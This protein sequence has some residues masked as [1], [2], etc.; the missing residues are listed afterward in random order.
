MKI[1]IAGAGIVGRLLAWHL[2]HHDLEVHLFDQDHIAG[3]TACSLTAGGMISP[4]AELPL[5]SKPAMQFGEKALTWWHKIVQSLSHEVGFQTKGTL[6]IASPAQRALLQHFVKAIKQ[7]KPE[8]ELNLLNMNEVEKLEPEINGF[9]GCYL[10]MEAWIDPVKL[11]KKLGIYFLDQKLKFH[12]HHVVKEI[13]HSAINT[14]SGNYIFN[15]VVDCRG[16][17]AKNA[18]PEIRGVRGELILCKAKEVN[19]SRMI[20]L[21]HPRFPCYLIPRD[22]QQYVIGATQIESESKQPI[23]IRSVLELLSAAVFVHSGFQE[24]NF[25]QHKV[26]CRPASFSNDPIVKEKDGVLYLNGMFRHGFLLAPEL[27]Y[28]AANKLCEIK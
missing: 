17:G 9:I 14:N 26:G 11:F 22:H 28:Q 1:G 13:T 16:L 6:V 20:R 7:V 3:K 10:P 5:L 2:C 12:S 24:A 18:L 4:I 19:I 8:C 27:T 25:I 15:K 23:T 21:L